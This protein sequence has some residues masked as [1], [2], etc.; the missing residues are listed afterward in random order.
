MLSWVPTGCAQ[1]GSNLLWREDQVL[2]LLGGSDAGTWPGL[3]GRDAHFLLLNITRV[4]RMSFPTLLS[5]LYSSAGPSPLPRG[6]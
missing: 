1:L 3:V 4:S 6:C 5:L 2:C